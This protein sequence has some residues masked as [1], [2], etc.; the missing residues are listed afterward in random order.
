MFFNIGHQ[1]LKNYPCHWHMGSFC[2]STDQGWTKTTVGTAQILYKGYADPAPLENLL[3]QILFQTEPML[4]GNFCALVLIDDAI[5]IQTDRYRSFPMYVGNGVNNLVST[6]HTAWTDS[7]ISVHADLSV[8]ETKF[9]VIGH[10]DVSPLTQNQVQQHIIEI[11]DQKAQ[12]LVTNTSYPIKVFLSGGVDSL[13]VYSFLKKH[14]NNFELVLGSH[15]DWDYFW[16]KNSNDITKNWAYTQIHHWNQDC[17]LTS[18]APGDEFMLRSPVTADLFLKYHGSGI[19]DLLTQTQWKNCL[20]QAY[21][22]IDKHQHIFASQK[23]TVSL[24]QQLHWDLCNTVANDWQHWHLGRTLTW[25]PL[26]DIEIFKLIL[27]LPLPDA[28]AQIMNSQLSVN[29]IEHNSPGLSGAISAQKNMHNHLAN[30]TDF[31]L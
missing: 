24:E 13:L 9:D 4:T 7:L 6:S 20:H 27:R 22:L 31:V 2:V 23:S 16:L 14:T 12:Q 1:P 29:I 28:T 19:A 11:L 25:T 5:K 3:E 17:V 8:T 21:F 30:L 18:G 26:R 10:I 15:L